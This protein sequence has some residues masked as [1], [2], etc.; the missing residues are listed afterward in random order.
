MKFPVIAQSMFPRLAAL[1]LRVQRTGYLASNYVTS[2]GV[3]V[4][5][6]AYENVDCFF[7]FTAWFAANSDFDER[8][9]E[10]TG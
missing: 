4:I 2:I 8:L 10:I 5:F 1:L 7:A 6:C 9:R 3:P